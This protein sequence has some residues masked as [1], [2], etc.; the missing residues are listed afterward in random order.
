MLLPLKKMN[1]ILGTHRLLNAHVSE[2]CSTNRQS[3]FADKCFEIFL[4]L[5]LFYPLMQSSRDIIFI[6][7][8]FFKNLFIFLLKRSSVC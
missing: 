6:Y 8:L 5:L 7:F 4:F 3:A 2:A 1:M